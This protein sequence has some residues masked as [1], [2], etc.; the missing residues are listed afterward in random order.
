ML[1][2]EYH[3]SSLN[4]NKIIEQYKLIHKNWIKNDKIYNIL[5]YDKAIITHDMIN[6]LGIYRSVIYSN[7]TINVFSPPKAVNISIFMNNYNEEDCIAEEYIEGTMINLFY[8]YD[9]DKW[10]IATKSSVGANIT[11]F[12]DQ[13]TFSKLFYEICNEFNIDFTMFNKDYCYSFVMQHPE[14]KFVKQ[15]CF[16][17]LYL[18]ACYKIEKYKITE[19]CKYSINIPKNILLP[20]K[21]DMLSYNDL[22]D[23]YGSMNTSSDILGIMIYHKNGSRTKIHNPNYTYIKHLRGNNTK[24]QYQYLCLR[25]NDLVKDNLKFF[26]ENKKQFIIFKTQLHIFTHTLYTNYIKCYIKKEQPLIEF[27]KQFRI[28]MFYLHKYYLSIREYKGYINKRVVIHYI[29][30]LESARLM[31]SL[32]YHM[33]NFIKT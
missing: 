4:D 20:E 15:I 22:L 24:L 8:D 5:K 14:N 9:I 16:K 12:K 33:H 2:K 29:N 13:P 18:I 11:F 1:K 26:P 3:L 21:H 17:R 32:N 7:N 28:H 6:T 19:I 25:K 30:N 31:Y 27:P 10:E 23:K